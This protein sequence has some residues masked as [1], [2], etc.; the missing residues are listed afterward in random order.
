[1]L[2]ILIIL[3]LP[4]SF[5]GRM[6][7]PSWSRN[8]A[9]C[10]LWLEK[11]TM[12]LAGEPMVSEWCKIHGGFMV[13][14]WYLNGGLMGLMVFEW[15]FKIRNASKCIK[16]HQNTSKCIK[17]P[18]LCEWCRP[19]QKYPCFEKENRVFDFH[20]FLHHMQVHIIQTLGTGELTQLLLSQFFNRYP[21]W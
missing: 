8:S 3:H 5:P 14:E 17:M 12:Y 16:M 11:P 15:A 19:N 6:P 2:I 9:I 7:C 21:A 4:A 1:M 10:W 18:K 13:V 20:R